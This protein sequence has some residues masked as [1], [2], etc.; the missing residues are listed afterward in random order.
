MAHLALSP[1]YNSNKYLEE[2][3]NIAGM[4]DYKWPTNN[5]VQ[6][7]FQLLFLAMA[8]LISIGEI[9]QLTFNN[10]FLFHLSSLDGQFCFTKSI[11]REHWCFLLYWWH[12]GIKGFK[13][14]K[15]SM[16]NLGTVSS[17]YPLCYVRTDTGLRHLWYQ[18]QCQAR[19]SQKEIGFYS[20]SAIN[21]FPAFRTIRLSI[22]GLC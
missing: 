12:E 9:Q 19:V 2:D 7:R 8:L 10:F 17:K 3:A 14:V 22:R 4:D 5:C 6:A 20:V 1:V 15:P 16:N 11:S 13:I 21:L 18:Q